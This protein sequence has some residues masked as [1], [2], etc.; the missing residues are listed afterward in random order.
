M[1]H[2]DKHPKNNKCV[3]KHFSKNHFRNYF[4]ILWPPGE[5]KKKL[6]KK[7]NI[8]PLIIFLIIGM[9]SGTSLPFR[10][11]S[12]AKIEKSYFYLR[13]DKCIALAIYIYLGLNK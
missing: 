10:P 8:N 5:N 7:V 4:Y 6:T 12:N 11:H 13:Q 1:H 9:I 2:N 3:G